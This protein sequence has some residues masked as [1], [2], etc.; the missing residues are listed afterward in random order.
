VDGRDG[1]LDQPLERLPKLVG[2]ERGIATGEESDLRGR[3]H[4]AGEA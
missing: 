3:E 1:T 4:D 2:F